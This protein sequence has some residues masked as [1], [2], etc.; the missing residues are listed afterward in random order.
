MAHFPY[1]SLREG[2]SRLALHS[3]FALAARGYTIMPWNESAQMHEDKAWQ[4]QLNSEMF[5]EQEGRDK[6]WLVV[7]NM[8]FVC[9]YFGNN[10]P[11]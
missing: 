4:K 7:W 1:V 8:N 11:N 3:R 9:P 6:L 5:G 2:I 10:H